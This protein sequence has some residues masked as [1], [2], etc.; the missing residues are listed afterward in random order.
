MEP[1]EIRHTRREIQGQRKGS[2]SF[3]VLK[4]KTGGQNFVIPF[5]VEMPYP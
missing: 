1:L 5:G 4:R 3:L 2:K